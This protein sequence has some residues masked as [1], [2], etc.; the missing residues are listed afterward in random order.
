MY[1]ILFLNGTGP[2]P[3]VA[4]ARLNVLVCFLPAQPLH[5]PIKEAAFGRL[6]EGGR[7]CFGRA[8]PFVE[9]FMCGCAVGQ[10]AA[11]TPKH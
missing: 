11:S 4:F 9:S 1:F 7:A 6:H 2:T 5:T 10:A 3:K 8:P